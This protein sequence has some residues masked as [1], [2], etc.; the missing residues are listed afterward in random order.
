MEYIKSYGL[1]CFFDDKLIVGERPYTYAFIEWVD[2]V[3]K[4][5]GNEHII[6]NEFDK[7]TE[8]E[9]LLITT[10]NAPSLI[11]LIKKAH[12]DKKII[13]QSYNFYM[14]DNLKLKIINHYKVY[15][16]FNF[17]KDQYKYDIPKGRKLKK[18][19]N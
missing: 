2:M 5:K 19:R 16:P 18:N 12:V 13:L 6:I 11:D 3:I 10:I 15:S 1:A 7:L 4:Y 14:T 9:K 8:F 17:K